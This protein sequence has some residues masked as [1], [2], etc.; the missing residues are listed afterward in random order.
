MDTTGLSL[1][2]LLPQRS[3]QLL[4]TYEDLQKHHAQ[5]R[6]EKKYSRTLWR[7]LPLSRWHLF[8]VQRMDINCTSSVP[9]FFSPAS[10]RHLKTM[11]IDKIRPMGKTGCI[12]DEIFTSLVLKHCWPVACLDHRC[13]P[14]SNEAQQLSTELSSPLP[15]S[16]SV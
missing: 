2:H 3:L 10:Y 16:Q 7:V 14:T 9:H 6:K 15:N 13:F 11:W 8:R 4:N 12:S 5:T 1:G